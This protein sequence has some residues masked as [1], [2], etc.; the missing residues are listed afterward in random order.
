MKRKISNQEVTSE[1]NTSHEPKPVRVAR[2]ELVVSPD[3]QDDGAKKDK[4]KSTMVHDSFT[5]VNKGETVPH[6]FGTMLD[7]SFF[8]GFLWH[9]VCT[10]DLEA[11]SE[12]TP[13]L[14]H[15]TAD[16]VSGEMDSE[17]GIGCLTASE[18]PEHAAPD[19]LAVCDHAEDLLSNDK[20]N[21]LPE[22]IDVCN[23]NHR[24]GDD[25]S[26]EYQ[27][28]SHQL[29][30]SVQIWAATVMKHRDSLD[31]ARSPKAFVEGEVQSEAITNMTS[32]LTGVSRQHDI[33]EVHDLPICGV[34][35]SGTRDNLVE[36]PIGDTH[37]RARSSNLCRVASSL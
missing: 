31:G 13:G 29:A 16:D 22:A 23:R 26:Q 32:P 25:Q 14:G 7:V 5:M 27:H 30:H 11:K 6:S 15:H 20:L 18:I 34:A 4:D 1:T 33:H 12:A 3:A 37:G 8:D 17:P 35:S 36:V 10:T 9:G 24:S 2:D 28:E 19:G 21:N